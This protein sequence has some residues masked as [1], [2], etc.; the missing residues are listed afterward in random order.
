MKRYRYLLPPLFLVAIVLLVFRELAFTDRI[1]GRGDTLVYFYPYWTVR[2]AFLR[3]GELPLWTPDLFMGIPLL[4]NPQLGTLYPPNWLTI[5]LDAPN[6]I[7]FSILLHVVWAGIGAYW[8]ARQSV[9]LRWQGAFVTATVYA[10]GGYLGAHTEQINQLQGL[11]WFPWLFGLLHLA[12]NQPQWRPV[13]LLGMALALQVLSGHTQ[14]VFISGIGMGIYALTK[15]SWRGLIPLAFASGFALLLA[16]P[17]IIPTL[18][19]ISQSGRS[20]GLTSN[21][22]LSFSLNPFIAGRGL[23]PSYDGKVFSEY[24]AY[25][26][27]IGITLAAIGSWRPMPREWVILMVLGLFLAFGAYNPVNWLIVQIP[28][29]DLFRVPARWLAL[30]GL[31]AS[32]LAGIGTERLLQNDNLSRR[33]AWIG[34][35]LN[36][37]LIGASFLALRVPADVNGSAA[38]TR[39]TLVA[40]GFALTAAFIGL[41]APV[42]WRIVIVPLLVVELIA[43]SWIMPYNDLVP[44]DVWAVHRFSISQMEVYTETDER[45]LTALNLPPPRLLSISSLFFDPGDKTTLSNR[46]QA[47][48]MT[49]LEERYSF[50][51]AK[52]KETL[53]PNL[54]LAWSIP[55]V[56]GFGG[57]LLPTIHY[58][59]FMQLVYPDNSEIPTDGRL[60]ENLAAESCRGACIPNEMWLQMMDVQYLITDKVYDVWGD[61]ISVDT[62]LPAQRYDTAVPFTA[63]QIAVVFQCEQLSNCT[64]SNIVLNTPDGTA[65]NVTTFN[66]TAL[67]DQVAYAIGEFPRRLTSTIRVESDN[68]NTVILGASLVDT[69]TDTFAFMVPAPDWSRLLSSDIKLYRYQP[70]SM[71]AVLAPRYYLAPS[72]SAALQTIQNIGAPAGIPVI[73]VQNGEQIPTPNRLLANPGTIRFSQY[74]PTH[75]ELSVVTSDEMLMVLHDAYYPGWHATVNGEFVR[76]YRANVN[77]RAIPLPAGESQVIFE[78]R[79]WWLPSVFI[80]GGLTWVIISI[81]TAL[82]GSIKRER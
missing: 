71:R 29:F 77:F 9:G 47:L 8:L 69:Q 61:G 41:Y 21:A 33:A 43:A 26:G 4:A 53:S 20:G 51:A 13:F 39:I 75:V 52:L 66:V 44:P 15:N 79:P 70:Q 19:L 65:F 10:C 67:D 38:P 28:L 81:A 57:G 5:G 7:R 18:E 74:N 78:Y 12:L 49:P 63:D 32:V 22:A 3:A 36:L 30:F 35:I 55:T 17:Q 34:I 14:T 37:I 1:L 80:F 59:T 23:L 82:R 11:A 42:R 54:P 46:Y 56:D 68:P 48:E 76:I 25:I 62:N 16:S 24:I 40:W 72:D 58:N 2:D 45:G 50:V 6:A 31:S 73:A 27:V 64:P 60:R